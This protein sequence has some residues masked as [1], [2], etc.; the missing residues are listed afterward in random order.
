MHFHLSVLDTQKGSDEAGQPV[1]GISDVVKEIE[2]HLF[3]KPFSGEVGLLFARG[4]NRTGGLLGIVAT[5]GATLAYPHNK[6]LSLV[7][8]YPPL[9]ARCCPGPSSGSGS[10]P[11]DIVLFGSAGSS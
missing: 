11:G 8:N 3:A 10:R 6:R 4:G 9:P 7:W 1:V 5:A 2:L